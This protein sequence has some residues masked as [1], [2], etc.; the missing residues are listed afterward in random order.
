MSGVRMA[1]EKLVELGE[2]THGDSGG[3]LDPGVMPGKVLGQTVP[4]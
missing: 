1:L 3:G 2:G 4:Q